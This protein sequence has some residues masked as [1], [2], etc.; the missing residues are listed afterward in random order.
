MK[1]I[2]S[3]SQHINGGIVC[4][5]VKLWVTI[6]SLGDIGQDITIE[7]KE[8]GAKKVTGIAS[9]WHPYTLYIGDV[10][11]CYEDER[12][13]RSSVLDVLSGTNKEII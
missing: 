9:Y 5:H 4:M 3:R 8:G 12:D 1:A 6:Y 10:Q 11:D 7:G 13:A 2:V